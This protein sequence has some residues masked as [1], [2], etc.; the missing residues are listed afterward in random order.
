MLLNQQHGHTCRLGCLTN[1]NGNG[2]AYQRGK[3]KGHL[4][5]HEDFGL[6]NHG[7]ADCEH[8]LLAP[9]Y[10]FGPT[11]QNRFKLREQTKNVVKV[12][13]ARPRGK[14]KILLNGQ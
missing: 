10:H 7:P 6:L 8:L 1:T 5:K 14:L 4:V 12:G 13:A 9:G 2:F 11:I 3:P